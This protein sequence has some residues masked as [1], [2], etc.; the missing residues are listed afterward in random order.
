M[1]L[2]TW[3]ID[4][5]VGKYPQKVA[6]AITKLQ[7][8]I[9]GVQYEP[10]AYLGSQEVNGTNHAVLAE[11]IVV[12]ER[13]SKNAV[14]LIFNEKPGDTEAT[15]IGI[16]RIVE[17]SDVFG[18]VN[19]DIN[20]EISDDLM[21]IWAKAFE[22][23][24]GARVTPFAFIGKQVVHG[25]NYIFAAKFSPAVQEPEDRVMLVIINDGE[26]NVRFVDML[27]TKYDASL[28]YAFTW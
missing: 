12:T 17:G 15:L 2:G 28:G 22:G 14:V 5:T 16:D 20:T 24:V 4:V 11:Q 26:M 1:S 8:T 6:S 10:I 7:E 23:Y 19:I 18:G 9:I 21:R 25:T 13:D 27:E 3:N